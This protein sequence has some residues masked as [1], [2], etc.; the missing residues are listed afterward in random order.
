M[1]KRETAH[2]D[3]GGIAG[4]ILWLLTKTGELLMLDLV[5]WLCCLPVVTIGPAAAALYYAAVKSVRRGLS[6]PVREFFSLFRRKWLTGLSLTVFF[7]LAA[8]AL[9]AL[10]RRA[11]LLTDSAGSAGMLTSQGAF[12]LKLYLAAAA[13]LAVL[14]FYVWPALSRFEL[15]AGAQLKLALV[16]AVRALPLTAALAAGIAVLIRLTAGIAAAGGALAG[17]AASAVI[18]AVIFLPAFLALAW[19]C[20]MEKVLRRYMP[21]ATEETQDMWYYA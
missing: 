4:R 6:Y 5:F 14:S 20:P 11:L 13:A 21:P 1:R 12:L 9:A 8:L 10:S 15:G 16:M 17:G 7:A 18:P 3:G 2:E 19:S